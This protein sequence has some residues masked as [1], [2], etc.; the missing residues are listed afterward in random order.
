MQLSVLPYKRCIFGSSHGWLFTIDNY[1]SD[2]ITLVHPLSNR[3]I[4]L[5]ELKHPENNYNYWAFKGILSSDPCL[6]PNDYLVLVIYK[7]MKKL[8]SLRPG[9]DK[10]W[11]F[12]NILPKQVGFSFSDALFYKGHIYAVNLW[13]ALV[14]V[15]ISSSTTTSSTNI[16]RRVVTEPLPTTGGLPNQVYIVQS[17]QEGGRLLLVQR[18]QHIGIDPLKADFHVYKLVKNRGSKC[19]WDKVESLPGEALFL[20]E[21]YSRSIV[22][23]SQSTC[24]WFPQNCIYYANHRFKSKDDTGV[25]RLEDR[26]FGKHFVP[27]P[28][29]HNHLSSF[30][31]IWI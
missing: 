18:I 17:S 2:V 10:S 27:D 8:A 15:D 5:P 4:R 20:G 26:S 25:F 16:N 31:P 9:L 30:P 13:S 11:K 29:R 23:S 21:N 7:D 19:A 1:I 14:E 3:T 28:T 12:I 22:V 24:S 6:N